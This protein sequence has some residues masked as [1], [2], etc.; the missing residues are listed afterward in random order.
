[1]CPPLR[2]ATA[3]H[4]A[5]SAA[6]ATKHDLDLCRFADDAL[7]REGNVTI[8][9][10][11]GVHVALHAVTVAGTKL[12]CTV[13]ITVRPSE[14]RFENTLNIEASSTSADDI[15]STV[16]DCVEAN[17]DDLLRTQALPALRP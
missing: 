10:G 2:N 13:S 16:R 15:K 11:R 8:A 6:N 7:E 5:V 14:K 1:M 3:L 9:N 17:V 12:T 4:L